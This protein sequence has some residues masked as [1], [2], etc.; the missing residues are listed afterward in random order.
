[1]TD[2]AQILL[3]DPQKI[4]IPESN[5]PERIKL[6]NLTGLLQSM[7]NGQIVP[8]IVAR[9]GERW[10]VLE[11]ARR[12]VCCRIL[13]TLLK[14]VEHTGPVTP[15][16]LAETR[17]KANQV[18]EKMSDTALAADFETLM[19]AKGLDQCQLAEH[20]GI[21][22]GEVS[23]VLSFPKKA[24]PKVLE[25][26]KSGILCRASCREIANA[27]EDHTQQ[28]QLLAIVLKD[29]SKPLKRDAIASLVKRMRG[30]R[31]RA[32]KE[33]KGKLAVV[34]YCIALS[35]DMKAVVHDLGRLYEA[36]KKLLSLGGGPDAL[37]GLAK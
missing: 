29:P 3:I 22:P 7:A 16:T 11:G 12:T 23:R 26:A 21:S 15:E 10:T 30:K 2:T 27:S 36:A 25:A 34:A 14:A 31:P 17:I 37:P 20:Y 8:A 4:D 32:P 13:G 18:R 5:D 35:S 28:D 9:N 33:V 1:M 19:R 6:E 24:S